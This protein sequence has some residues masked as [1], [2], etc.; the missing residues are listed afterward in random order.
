MDYLI[1]KFIK[2]I[3]RPKCNSILKCFKAAYELVNF[4]IKFLCTRFNRILHLPK[5]KSSFYKAILSR[6]KARAEVER[7]S[8]TKERPVGWFVLILPPAETR[9]GESQKSSTIRHIRQRRRTALQGAS[10]RNISERKYLSRRR[11]RY[12]H[13][14]APSS[15]ND[16][17]CDPPCSRNDI[18]LP[19]SL[20]A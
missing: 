18:P 15:P 17:P 2:K 20:P 4:T 10:W 6:Q 3:V 7:T 5:C 1:K 9:Y 11:S 16:N 14:I 12:P 19:R 8:R 13:N